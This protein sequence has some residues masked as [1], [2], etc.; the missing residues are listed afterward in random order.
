MG[1]FTVMLISHTQQN[2]GGASKGV[3]ERV[4]IEVD[5]LGG[6]VEQ[7]VSGSVSALADRITTSEAA[8]TAVVKANNEALI[9]YAERNEEE[10]RALRQTVR[11][12]EERLSRLEGNR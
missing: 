2:R 9:V 8:T 5:V 10:V 1:W 6:G 3:G 12:L 4:N 11:D 7:S